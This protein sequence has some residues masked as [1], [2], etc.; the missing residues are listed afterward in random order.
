MVLYTSWLFWITLLWRHVCP[1]PLKP[2]LL[3]LSSPIAHST[4]SC[5]G[6]QW[7]SQCAGWSGQLSALILLDLSGVFGT[8]DHFSFLDSLVW[9]CFQDIPLFW[10]SSYFTRLSRSLFYWFPFIYSTLNI[11]GLQV[12][13]SD[14]FPSLTTLT[15]PWRYHGF[16]YNLNTSD[17]KFGS[18]NFKSQAS[19]LN[20]RLV[21]PLVNL[22]YSLG[23]LNWL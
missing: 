9:L 17:T 2:A 4:C 1:F 14:L 23:C 12:L 19:P 13:S 11:G 7:S 16:K 15:L 21:Y 18:P 8:A 10:S 22:L 20:S 3:K 5:Q 6:K